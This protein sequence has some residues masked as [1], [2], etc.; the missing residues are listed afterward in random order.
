MKRVIGLPGEEIEIRNHQVR[1]N[2]ETLDE[3]YAESPTH[4]TLEP[5]RLG[6]DQIFLM[7]DNRGASCDSRRHG[8]LSVDQ[9]VARAIFR[10]RPLHR[11]G[12][13]E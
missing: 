4:G 1:I 7:G 3:P 13:L 2:G 8:P 11:M 5:L 10:D 12:F 6:S 9:V